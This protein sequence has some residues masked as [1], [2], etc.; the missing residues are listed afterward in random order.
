[1]RGSSDPG[2]DVVE[3]FNRRGAGNQGPPCWRPSGDLAR[4]EAYVAAA[5]ARL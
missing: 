4:F 1:M 5:L 3:N 2:D